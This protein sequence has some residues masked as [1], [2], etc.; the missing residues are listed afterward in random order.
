MPVAD[1]TPR[2]SSEERLRIAQERAGLAR[3]VIKRLRR[4]R[5]RRGGETGQGVP[6]DRT[7]PSTLGGGAAAVLSFDDQGG[8]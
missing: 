8:S 7:P 1:H 2:M 6:V 3:V 5:K 4:D